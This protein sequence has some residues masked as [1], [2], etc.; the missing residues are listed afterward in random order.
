MAKIRSGILG[1]I[2]GKVAGVVGGQWKD[3]NYLREFVKPA[4]P[5]TASQQT[6]RTAMS[7]V[8]A[9]CKTL[10]GPVFNAYTD[11]FQKS[12]SGFNR[13]IKDNIAEF[14]GA[15]DYS[16]LI[17]TS[18]PLFAPV[19]FVANKPAANPGLSLEWDEALG[20]NGALTDLMYACAFN[21]STGFWYFPGAE[22]ERDV[23]VMIIT[24]P[25]GDDGTDFECYLWA[26]QKSG[27]VVNMISDAPHVQGAIP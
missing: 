17:V 26:A 18:G 3:V 19:S 7:D 23:E 5:N 6:Q 21:T 1:N 4:N 24:V 15:V 2:R 8:V 20:N 13:F 9:F 27:T 10:V 22:V 25:A 16:A 11:K 12:M 14:D